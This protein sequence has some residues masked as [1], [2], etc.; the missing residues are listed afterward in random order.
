LPD[1]S[2]SGL[3]I[4]YCVNASAVALTPT[5]TGGT[6]SGTGISGNTF[7]PST[8][9]AGTYTITYAIT[10]TN[11]C[12]N[13]SN[14]NV[15]VNA[16]PDASFSGLDTAYCISASPV[17]LTPITN[18]GTFTGSG[19]TGNSFDPSVAGL[20][21][22]TIT[23]SITL[24]GCSNS[25]GQNVHISNQANASFSGLA[26]TYCSNDSSIVLVPAI[27]GGNFS[28]DGISG[29]TFDPSSAGAGH[30]V[31][32]YTVS[33]G[34]CTSTQNENVQVK[35]APNADFANLNSTYCSNDP[36]VDLAPVQN[37]GS[38]NGSVGIVGKKFFPQLANLGTN[39]IQ[40]T[41]IFGNGCSAS[42]M[43][44]TDVV[45]PPFNTVT[46]TGTTMIANQ[47]GTGITYQWV[48]CT[49][50]PITGETNQSFTPTYN[51][52]FAVQV[53]NGSCT[54]TSDCYVIQ[55]TGINTFETGNELSVYP[56]PNTGIF[57]LDGN[58]SDV[59]LEII[60][61]TGKLIYSNNHVNAGNT[62]SI[63]NWLETGM[64][65]LKITNKAG[66]VYYKKMIIRKD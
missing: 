66:G 64:Y 42:K 3:A 38:F 6:F 59:K 9:G 5:Q 26:S 48:T 46:I 62:V 22:F 54:V 63:E 65:T 31:I 25:S 29:N 8:A 37:G 20:G 13:T 57:T 10:D 17:T 47:I 32:S 2:F 30:H 61:M 19:I 4:A 49:G 40:Y 60:N 23:Y 27:S 28:G 18:G 41:I 52:S 51:G 53:S 15:N 56:N 33:D 14:A 11:N 24:A 1:A 21:Y 12:T 36:F 7:D 45:A 44:T 43:D 58:F 35:I 50:V 55:Y 39:Y 34:V 16:I